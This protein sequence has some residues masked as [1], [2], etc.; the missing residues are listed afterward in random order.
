M[1]DSKNQDGLV[2]LTSVATTEWLL[3]ETTLYITFQCIFRH[4]ISSLTIRNP[5][6]NH[7]TFYGALTMVH[8]S[9][10]KSFYFSLDFVHV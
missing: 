7:E 10:I 1:S 4:K 6:E 9:L 3:R 8:N 2:G 5:I